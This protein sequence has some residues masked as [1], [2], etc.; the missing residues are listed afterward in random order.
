MYKKTTLNN[1]L[2]IVTMPMPQTY[3]V[4]L[5][6]FIGAGG[7][8]E[9]SA[10][11]G[12]SHFIEHICFKGTKRRVNSKEISETIDGVGGVLNGATNHEITLYWAKVTR[13]HFNL[14]LDL[15][16][17]LIRNS[18][19]EEQDIN[20]ERKVIIEE[21]NSSLDSPQ[22]RVS[23]L[24]EDI[25]WPDQPLGRDVAG[26]KETLNNINRQIMLDFLNS[27][28][29]PNN[30]VIS[31]AGNIEH[32]EIVDSINAM[33]GDWSSSKPGIWYPV[34]DNQSEPRLIVEKRSI[35]QVNL[36]LAVKGYSLF[37]PDRFVKDLINVIL[38]KGM[39]SRLFVNIREKLGL[40]YDIH[41]YTNSFMDAGTFTIYAG[42][43]PINTSL[44]IKSILSEM[45]KLRQEKVSQQE[46]TKVKEM[47]KGRLLLRMEDTTNVIMGIGSQ[48]IL[49]KDIITVDQL[50]EI[51]DMITAEDIQRVARDIFR[52]DKLSLSIVGPVK[53]EED[54]KSILKL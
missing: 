17:D 33:L 35:E 42:V 7:R 8:Y 45:D 20:K 36:C 24:L 19:F 32:D 51:V 1:G 26:T 22:E 40:A 39:S 4:C 13:P 16:V 44:A 2:R 15:L 29:I 28:Y 14:A 52:T 43:D 9:D 41:S 34:I 38:G 46:L 53:T 11:S 31:V 49:T 25:M 23:M 54:F 27:Q 5:G 50:I 18:R 30:T 6:F 21:I 48:E 12:L 3:S 47:S 37:H 10:I